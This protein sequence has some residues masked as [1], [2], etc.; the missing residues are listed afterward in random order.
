MNNDL[1]TALI[2]YIFTGEESALVT[3]DERLMGIL[4]SYGEGVKPNPEEVERRYNELLQ[5]EE[6]AKKAAPT[7]KEPI[8]PEGQSGANVI[9]D[10]KTLIEETRRNVMERP[11]ETPVE[12]EY[13]PAATLEE[14]SAVFNQTSPSIPEAKGTWV[15]EQRTEAGEFNPA[16]H[17]HK[18]KTN[19]RTLG[20]KNVPG[21]K[22]DQIGYANIVLMSIIVI[23]IVAIICVFIF[24]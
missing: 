5:Q 13:N 12:G 15:N 10:P 17:E 2:K 18:F 21:G 8:V 20:L 3:R 22:I 24:M 1:K 14:A 23:I 7:I 11:L 9:K 16:N 4:N 6:L 19:N